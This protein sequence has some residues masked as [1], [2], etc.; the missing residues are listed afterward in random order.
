MPI[1]S[2]QLGCFNANCLD[3][4]DVTAENEVL[5]SVF[6]KSTLLPSI[7]LTILDQLEKQ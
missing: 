2:H 7:E 6:D 5:H 3:F 4:K 1:E